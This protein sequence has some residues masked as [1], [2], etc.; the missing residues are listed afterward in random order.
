MAGLGFFTSDFADSLN[1]I[2]GKND[3]SAI[4]EV[5]VNLVGSKERTKISV[6]F[7]G[8]AIKMLENVNRLS[9]AFF[10]DTMLFKPSEKVGYTISKGKDRKSEATK[11]SNY[12]MQASLGDEDL[13]NKVKDFIGDYKFYKDEPTGLFYIRKEKWTEQTESQDEPHDEPHKKK[14]KYGRAWK[15]IRDK[16]A[17]LNPYC[18]KCGRPTEEIHHIVPLCKGGSHSK[19]NLMALCSDCH[20]KIHEKEKIHEMGK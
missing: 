7:R 19:S 20:K 12:Y 2:S 1:W 18:E 17:K 15:R 6:I 11:T 13:I 8:K 9:F 5:S 16:Y 14:N 3:T 10:G 4:A